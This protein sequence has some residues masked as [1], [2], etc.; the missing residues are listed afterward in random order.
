MDLGFPFSLDLSFVV[1]GGIKIMIGGIKIM[2][3][4]IK[5]MVGFLLM[6]AGTIIMQ[7]GCRENNLSVFLEILLSWYVTFTVCLLF[8]R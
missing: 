6:E 2:V 8:M 1:V 3:G 5:I 7:L 4:G